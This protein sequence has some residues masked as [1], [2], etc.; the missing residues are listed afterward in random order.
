MGTG[1]R[2]AASL[3]IALSVAG[4][5]TSGSAGS[6]VSKEAP[7]ICTVVDEPITGWTGQV[8]VVKLEATYK[9]RAMYA[10]GLGDAVWVTTTNGHD[11]GGVVLP[12]NDA[13]RRHIPPTGV[14]VDVSSSGYAE[15]A[16]EAEDAIA[17][18]P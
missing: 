3:A 10:W 9:G 2:L 18:C 8:T 6:S 15:G 1:G 12:V 14:G 13:A 16:A 11:R 7:Q 17:A 5:S 4:C